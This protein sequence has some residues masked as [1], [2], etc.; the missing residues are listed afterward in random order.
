MAIGRDELLARSGHDPMVRWTTG[1]EVLAVASDQGWAYVDPWR[2]SG[3]WGGL[4]EVGPG[5]AAGAE[6]GALAALLELAEVRSVGVEWFSTA[7]HRP[8][9]TPTGHR[10]TGSGRWT[11]MVTT[12]AEGLPAAPEGLVE[13][14]DAE[15]T[16]QIGDFGRSH[17]PDFEGHPG[18]GLA[19]LW[20]GVRDRGGLA[21]VGA[22]HT[23]AT[24]APHLAG[25]VV[26]PDLR[27]RGVGAGLTAE[28]TRRA[29]ARHGVAT[30]G[31]YTANAVAVRLYERL[32]Y[33]VARHLH[34]RSLAPSPAVADLG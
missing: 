22:L 26:R 25:I 4:A 17:N 9:A 21:A 8:L 31:V 1:P 23:L 7:P 28:L 18:R 27:G 6:D 30:L 5:A 34:T 24:G 29:V 33:A 13:L 3:H 2:P 32:G 11:F 14:D 16:Q 10:I 15:D 12:R 19:S 20:L